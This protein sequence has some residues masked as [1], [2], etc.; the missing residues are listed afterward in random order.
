[1]LLVQY[2][3]FLQLFVLRCLPHYLMMSPASPSTLTI[4]WS[5]GL[6]LLSYAPRAPH[7]FLIIQ[8]GLFENWSIFRL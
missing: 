2:K 3:T 5:F 1:M 4:Q 6:H 8:T 7:A